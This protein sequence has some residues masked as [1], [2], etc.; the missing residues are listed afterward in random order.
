[1]LIKY[2]DLEI[3]IEKTLDMRDRQ[4]FV[5]KVERKG[6]KAQF[7]LEGFKPDEETSAK[8]KLYLT[9]T[10]LVKE[11]LSMENKMLYQDVIE[12]MEK[13]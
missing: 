12:M 6:K 2:E 7:F 4:E 11:I 1:M 5:F 3:Y 10:K 9:G 13:T 8:W